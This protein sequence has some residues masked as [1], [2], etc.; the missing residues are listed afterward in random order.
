MIHP[1]R[2]SL[3]VFFFLY[4]LTINLYA[5]HDHPDSEVCRLPIEM[6][7]QLI[8]VK[9]SFD[10][11]VGNFIIDTGS[12][13]LILNEKLVR[14]PRKSRSIAP[15]GINGR[16]ANTRETFI[17][18]MKLGPLEL[19]NLD[20]MVMNLSHIERARKIP[21]A[22][23]IGYKIL[24]KYEVLFDFEQGELL[25]YNLNKKGR[26][27]GQCFECRRAPTDSIDFKFVGHVPT[28]KTQFGEKKVYLGIDSGAEVNLIDEKWKSVISKQLK[29]EENK[30][31][32]G[33]DR[34]E[35]K[36]SSAILK[37]FWIDCIVFREMQTVFAQNIASFKPDGYRSLDGLLG[38]EFLK[39]RKMA[40]NF[41]QKKI[42][43]WGAAE[44]DCHLA[45]K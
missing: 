25:L 2:S 16:I 3:L 21:I 41:R 32:Y 5:F 8:I 22:G 6:A 42:Y 36:A 31:L 45:K 35:M 11:Q 20:A 34:K 13:S 14:Y 29:N 28:I 19:K 18:R 38:Y 24:K 17:K 26:I 40:I 39:Q 4:T 44:E 9:A 27:L 33:L 43:F 30:S 7:G 37:S 12:P 10:G 1:K 23:L 15:K